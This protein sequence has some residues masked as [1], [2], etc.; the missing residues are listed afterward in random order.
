MDI[1]VAS[2][3]SAPGIL[4]IDDDAVVRRTMLMLLRARGFRAKAY[5]LGGALISDPLAR[6]A[7]LLIAN[8]QMPDMS[9][10]DVLVALRTRGWGGSAIMLTANMNADIAPSAARNGFA[11]TLAKPVADHV[12]I[13]MVT[14]LVGANALSHP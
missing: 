13:D 9:G 11:V 14:R 12:L 3:E 7:Q 10:V 4:L 5:G 1:H 8:W 6:F 2:P